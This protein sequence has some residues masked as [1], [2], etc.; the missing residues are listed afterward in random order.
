MA[1]HRPS[2]P[3]RSRAY[4]CQSANFSGFEIPSPDMSRLEISIP[5]KVWYR[6]RR[7]HRLGRS[8][9]RLAEKIASLDP[10]DGAATFLPK[11]RSVAVEGTED[12][13]TLVVRYDE[14]EELSSGINLSRRWEL[15]CSPRAARS[16]QTVRFT[17][18]PGTLD[19]V[20]EID[21][22]WNIRE[23][24]YVLKDGAQMDKAL[25]TF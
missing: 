9:G 16:E 22:L 14:F 18:L 21:L 7:V 15:E 1:A 23:A 12:I 24:L 19:E 4:R 13:D 6:E 10:S 3:E 5:I 25:S 11:G 20:G 17:E 8:I 2:D